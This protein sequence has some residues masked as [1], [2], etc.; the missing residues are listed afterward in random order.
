[1]KLIL[2]I[3][4]IIVIA[5]LLASSV[6]VIFFTGDDVDNEPP[7]ID[8]ITRDTSGKKGESITISVTFSDNINVTNA[9]IF[10]KTASA[11]NWSSTSILSGSV[12]IYIP[13]NSD[14]NWYYY[15]T[16]D[17]AAGNGPVGDPS[18]NG[19]TYYTITVLDDGDNGD[20][21]FVHTVFIEEATATWCAPCPQVAAILHDLYETENYQFYYVSMVHD[22]NDKAEERL[23]VDY[24]N[25]GFP[26]VY[27]DGGYKVV[28]T[29]EDKSVY[30]DEISA[31]LL[32]NTPNLHISV[33]AVFNNAT[34]EM[35][36]DILVENGEKET[37]TG[38]LRV[39]LTEITSR[40]ADNDGN[41]YSFGFLDY[42]L[43]QEISIDAGDTAVVQKIKK[44]SDVG[45]SNLDPENLKIFAVVFSSEKNQGYSD[46]PDNQE[47]FDA[48][49]ADA[50]NATVLV[51]GGNQPPG[52]G[53]SIP[54]KG[55]WH[56]WGRP[57]FKT[58]FGNNTILIGKTTITAI[59][60]DDSNIEKVEFYIDEDLKS[61]VTQ[62][63]Y[64]WS[65]K[66]VAFIKH[67]RRFTIKVKA[68][69][70]TGKTASTSIDVISFRL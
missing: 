67:F 31:A 60:E 11:T 19:S 59:A 7:S 38:R 34:N 22:V 68:Y 53:I 50:V 8:T 51:P 12:N 66:R 25:L 39:Y 45:F 61:T 27:I 62:E 47:P 58:L 36:I 29:A 55:K 26:T 2:K 42:I 18:T 16:V 20:N 46:P 33:N 5:I 30:E 37:Y 63:P 24:N 41:P 69:D 17:D 28:F 43:N 57:L 3:A 14:E 49:Y 44:I 52:V 70:D 64:E 23:D 9:T 4:G 35:I 13:K 1:M 56:F 65:L 48:Y 54:V 10:Y 15:V 6:Y 40:W 32:R 21:E